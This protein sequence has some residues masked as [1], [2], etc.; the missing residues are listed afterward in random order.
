MAT[1]QAAATAQGVRRL[2]ALPV[3]YLQVQGLRRA[4]RF[5]RPDQLA[6]RPALVLALHGGGGDGERFRRFTNAT[7]ERLADEQGFLV[8]Y[9]DTLGGQWHG[10]RRRAPYH[11][12]LSGIDELAFLRAVAR[13]AA[14]IPAGDLV[15]VFVVGY[16]NGG[17]LVCR[18][19]LEGPHEFDALAAIGAHLPVSEE[20]DCTASHVPVSILLVS[21]TDDPINPWAGG[22]VR[23][24]GGGTLGHVL[25]AEA[26]AAYFAGLAGTI[27]GPTIEQH[28]DRDAEDGA[29]VETRRWVAEGRGE[30]V[31]MA[32][33]GGGH[34]LLLPTMRATREESYP[35]HTR[36][37]KRAVKDRS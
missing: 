29:Q 22:E 33:H 34:T 10:C 6:D 2:E 9:P 14:A 25:S 17:H 1:R 18:I 27:D 30:V 16:S 28:P 3:E 12:A 19:A 32:V 24:P 26:T 37:V 7:F 31:L 21:G 13:R 8:A 36:R 20:R 5:Y 4:V 23:P 35:I 15:G 11:T